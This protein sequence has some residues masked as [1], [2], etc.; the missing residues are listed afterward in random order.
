[1]AILKPLVTFGLF[2]S[3]NAF[4]IYKVANLDNY[5]IRDICVSTLS[6]DIACNLYICSFMELSY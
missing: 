2:L 1:M 3:V 6:A 5:N 4:C